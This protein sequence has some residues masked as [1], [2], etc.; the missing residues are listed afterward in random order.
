MVNTYIAYRVV[1]GALNHL[2]PTSPCA[3][4]GDDSSSESGSAS[5]SSLSRSDPSSASSV[6]HLPSA[7]DFDRAADAVC[8]QDGWEGLIHTLCQLSGSSGI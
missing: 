2:S 8:C 3:S 6:D 5:S 4:S 7:G 1:A